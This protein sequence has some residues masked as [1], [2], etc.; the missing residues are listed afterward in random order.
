ML[1]GLQTIGAVVV[2]FWIGFRIYQQALTDLASHRT[3]PWAAALL[4]TR[5]PLARRRRPKG[6]CQRFLDGL[7]RR[8]NHKFQ[9]SSAHRPQFVGAIP[10]LTGVSATVPDR[11]Q[12]AAARSRPG[13]HVSGRG[14]DRANRNG[15]RNGR[16]EIA[17]NVRERTPDCC[18]EHGKTNRSC[19]TLHNPSG[20]VTIHERRSLDPAQGN[21]GRH[22]T[23]ALATSTGAA[24]GAAP[25]NFYVPCRLPTRR[26]RSDG[27]A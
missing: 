10:E 4:V 11:I 1:F 23:F 22:N 24:H 17:S 9:L 20:P 19:C 14:K 25:P 12:K 7:R 3:Q 18:R 15:E 6:G 13:R 26:A 27:G 8:R 5:R 16:Q 2:I 21:G